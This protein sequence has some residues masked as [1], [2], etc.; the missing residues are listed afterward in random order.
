M[1]AGIPRHRPMEISEIIPA[2]FRLY[3]RNAWLFISVLAVALVPQAILDVISPTLSAVS[4]ITNACGLG[5]LIVAI[6]ARYSGHNIT[7]AGAYSALVIT[8]LLTLLVTY[9]A[10][11]VMTAL[12][13][14][15]LVVPGIY[16]MV[17]FAFF[18]PAVVLERRSVT[19]ALSR[20]SDLVRGHWWHVCAVG[21]LAALTVGVAQGALG[22]LLRFALPY[23][24]SFAVGTLAGLLVLPIGVGA[25]VLLYY[26]LRLRTEGPI[27]TPSMAGVR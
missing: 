23:R 22:L 4:L 13:L 8:T 9:L 19:G 12:G 24:Y 3:W 10:Y 6:S 25:L 14:V 27:R 15:L 2:A 17:R 11:V 18:A 26:D 5:A 20:S 1:D 16:L 21:I 7:I